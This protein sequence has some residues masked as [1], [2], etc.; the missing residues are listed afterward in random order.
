MCCLKYED[1]LYT[2]FRKDLPEVGDEIKNNGEKGTVI[3]IDIPARKYVYVTEE[4]NKVE[5]K[6]PFKNEKRRES[7]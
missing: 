4:G 6:V 3:S 7:N 1:D 5:V 2:E